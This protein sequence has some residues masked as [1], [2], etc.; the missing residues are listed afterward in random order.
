MFYEKIFENYNRDASTI[1]SMWA[2]SDRKNGLIEIETL[3]IQLAH[4]HALLQ[5]RT[6]EGP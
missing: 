5:R 1:S 3:L 4:T 2:A 6:V